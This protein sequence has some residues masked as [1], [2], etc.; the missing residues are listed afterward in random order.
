MLTMN[1]VAALMTSQV[2]IFDVL[3]LAR[4]RYG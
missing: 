3:L 4:K 1:P 2:R